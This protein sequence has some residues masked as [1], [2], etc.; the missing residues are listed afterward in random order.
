MRAIGH[1]RKI[2]RSM[3]RAGLVREIGLRTVL[4]DGQ[5]LDRGQQ[6][7]GGALQPAVQQLEQR[8][9]MDA[10][11]EGLGMKV[12]VMQVEHAA[13]AGG[14]AVEPVDAGTQRQSLLVEA[15]FAQDREAGG[16]QQQAGADRTGCGEAFD[17]GDAMSGIGQQSGDRLAADAAADD[18]DVEGN[19]HARFALT[20]RRSWDRL[21]ATQELSSWASIQQILRA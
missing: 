2:E 8:A 16:L 20:D 5:D 17:D 18:R 15:E 3:R 7:D 12:A 9:A 6:A 10:E 14:A 21:S 4:L 19:S 13:P 11:A 1:D